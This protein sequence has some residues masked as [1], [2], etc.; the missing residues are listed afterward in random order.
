MLTLLIQGKEFVKNENINV[1]LQP[2]VEKL[3]ELWKGVKTIDVTKLGGKFLLR[4]ICMWS[5]HNYLTYGL[6]V[7]CQTKGYLAY[8]LYGP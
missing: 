4:P 5:L 2:L 3:Q 8:P 1:Y 7:G 6:F